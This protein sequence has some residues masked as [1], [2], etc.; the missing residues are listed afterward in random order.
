[1]SEAHDALVCIGEKTYVDEKNR[2]NLQTT[3][4]KNI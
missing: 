1:M 4:L 2:K 3:L